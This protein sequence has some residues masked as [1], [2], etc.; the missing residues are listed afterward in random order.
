MVN[1]LE[2]YLLILTKFNEK[3]QNI[4]K[5]ALPAGKMHQHQSVY[6]YRATVILEQC[7]K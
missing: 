4:K 7:K 6:F 3:C 1:K 2:C 5:T